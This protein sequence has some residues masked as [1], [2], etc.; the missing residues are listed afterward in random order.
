MQAMAPVEHAGLQQHQLYYLAIKQKDQ[1]IS[2]R[3]LKLTFYPV[4]KQSLPLKQQ[5]SISI[6][7]I[8]ST[9]IY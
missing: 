6:K 5:L 1:G 2:Q 4:G 9:L 3:V 7:Q 8:Y